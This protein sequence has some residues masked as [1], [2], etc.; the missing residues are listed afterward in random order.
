M[1]R[2]VLLENKEFWQG[3]Y[4]L[5]LAQKQSGQ[6]NDALKN[7]KTASEGDG[8][9]KTACYQNMLEIYQK[10]GKTEQVNRLI[11]LLQKGQ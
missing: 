11:E 1:F 2:E 4:F 7:F 8:N 3:Y 9:L 10:Q 6:D 5:A